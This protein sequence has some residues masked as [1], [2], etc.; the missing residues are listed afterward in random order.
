MHASYL[1]RNLIGLFMIF[2]VKFMIERSLASYILTYRLE[3]HRAYTGV[4]LN[5]QLDHQAPIRS[6]SFDIYNDTTMFKFI[7][8]FITVITY[9]FKH[10]HWHQTIFSFFFHLFIFFIIFY[11]TQVSFALIHLSFL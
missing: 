1:I 8:I 11:F 9:S 10:Y 3:T 2:S 4:H 7:V 5:G 6:D